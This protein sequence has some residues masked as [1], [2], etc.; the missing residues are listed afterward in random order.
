MRWLAHI[1]VFCLSCTVLAGGVLIWQKTQAVSLRMQ[2]VS[3][4]EAGSVV[5]YKTTPGQPLLRKVGDILPG[6][7]SQDCPIG[8]CQDV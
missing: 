1:T 8:L 3:T 7:S 5:I 6:S 4:A 2:V